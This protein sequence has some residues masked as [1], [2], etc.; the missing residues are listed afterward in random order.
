MTYDTELSNEG[1]SFG[2][3]ISIL[4]VSLFKN[5]IYEDGDQEL[6]ELAKKK[7]THVDSYLIPF[8]LQLIVNETEGYAYLRQKEFGQE[9]EGKFPKL[10][11]R[12]QLS[13]RVSYL[14]ALL[15]KLL[16]ER[17]AQGGDPKLVVS[18]KEIL[19]ILTSVFPADENNAVRSAERVKSDILRILE[20]G[21]LKK[22]SSGSS[23]DSGSND[24][25]YEVR[26]ILKDF[27]DA[28]WLENLDKKLEEYKEMAQ[29]NER[30]DG[31]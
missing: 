3:D 17:D 6:F 8:G 19:N 26:R 13:F 25:L 5:V 9:L 28:Q 29:S 14:L 7:G 24:E 27:V 20:L 22:I 2:S 15:R 23:R 10:V 1:V 12:R 4:L 16:A 11:T 18:F 31:E 30:N 21:F